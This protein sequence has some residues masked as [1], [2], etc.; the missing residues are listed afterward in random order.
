VISRQ[1][2]DSPTTA[3]DITLKDL[4]IAIQKKA[5]VYDKGKK[6]LFMTKAAKNITI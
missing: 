6:R 3:G 4:E 1:K 2:P 5:L